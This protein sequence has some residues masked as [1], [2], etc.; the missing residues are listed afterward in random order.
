M[1]EPVLG[2]FEKVD[3]KTVWE[4][5]AGGFTPWLA[6]EEN[7]VLLG[8]AI[9]VELEL[10][11]TEK[12]VGPFRADI[13]CK[14]T[15]SGHWVLIENQLAKT[16]HT[17]LGQLLTYAA[18][19]KAVTI[20]WIAAPFTEEHRAALNWLNEITDDTF[21]F[22]G[23]EVELWR[24]GDSPPAPKFN[25]ISQPNDWTR[26]VSEGANRAQSGGLTETAER[27]LEYWS[28]L[29]KLLLEQGSVVRPQKAQPQAWTNFGVGRSFCHLAAVS[30]TKDRWIRAELYIHASNAKAIFHR[31]KS[32]KETI[33][34]EFDES[35][36]WEELP[37]KKA[38]RISIT[39]QDTDIK[40]RDDW[41]DQ[42]RWLQRNLE[43]MHRVFAPRLK[44]MDVNELEYPGHVENAEES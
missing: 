30:H 10:E 39:R 4:T 8:E 2:K 14:D 15:A 43:A 13:L 26:S 27:Y 38:S 20:V 16:D 22:F 18:G 21:N 6:R 32:E 41:A 3:L 44:H 33:E 11:A 36:E 42:H 19:L 9:D 7:L 35:F 34:S 37:G 24:I 31:L 28:G 1:S 12:N 23:L 40:K 17:H 25:I 29:R 5:E